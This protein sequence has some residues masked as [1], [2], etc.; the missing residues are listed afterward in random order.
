MIEFY[1]LAIISY[2]VAVEV[3]VPA[4][5]VVIAFAQGLV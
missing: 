3:V 4:V 2:G 1:T 5:Q